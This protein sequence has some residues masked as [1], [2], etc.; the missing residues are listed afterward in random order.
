MTDELLLRPPQLTCTSQDSVCSGPAAKSV[1][2]HV[3]GNELC[4]R[5]AAN[6]SKLEMDKHL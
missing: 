6:N 4:E 1:V 2:S 5:A 3:L